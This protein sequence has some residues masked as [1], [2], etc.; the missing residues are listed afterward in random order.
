MTKLAT[1]AAVLV[2]CSGAI[3]QTYPGTDD[4]KTAKQ[5]GCET[6]C[7][8]ACETSCET[9]CEG[10]ATVTTVALSAEAGCSQPATACEGT[11]VASHQASVVAAA[12]RS[13]MPHV[14]YCVGGKK[15]SCEIEAG[16]LAKASGAPVTWE[17]AG[18]GYETQDDAGRAYATALNGYL[19]TMTRV[20]F[21]VGDE[22]V[23]CPMQAGQMCETTGE[24]MRY[25]VGPAVFDSAEAA[26]KA[27]A[28]AYGA[29]RQVK[30]GHKVNGESTSC[31]ESIAGARACEQTALT[32]TVGSKETGCEIEASCLLA[33][34]RI[35]AA[36]DA[37]MRVAGQG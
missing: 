21:V 9:S 36:E 34:A 26:V 17:V 8:T 5:G 22:C 37:I 27:A 1:M 11:G 33:T 10:E 28:I 32:Y 13:G 30:L 7:E 35:Q 31:A 2:A 3:A 20:S 6:A 14:A 15:T 16:E 29:S 25:R 12:F 24:P 4:A 19:D 23:E 18:V